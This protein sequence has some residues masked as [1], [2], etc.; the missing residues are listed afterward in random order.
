VEAGMTAAQVY[1]S[2]LVLLESKWSLHCYP[3]G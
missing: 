2:F 3:N 1:L